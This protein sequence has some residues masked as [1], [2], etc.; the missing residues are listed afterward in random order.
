MIAAQS[1]PIRKADSKAGVWIAAS[2]TRNSVSIPAVV[3]TRPCGAYC[4]I[5]SRAAVSLNM[6]AG[7]NSS[8]S[9]SRT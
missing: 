6:P 7:K 8:R 5:S 2:M 1:W 3:A 9:V 4:A